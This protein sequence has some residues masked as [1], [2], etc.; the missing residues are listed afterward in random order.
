MTREMAMLR[1]ILNAEHIEWHDASEESE[2]C[3]IC[4]THFEH[5]GYKWSVIHG[6]GTYGGF[7]S[8]DKDKGLLEVMSDAINGGEPIGWLTAEEVMQYVKGDK[9]GEGDFFIVVNGNCPNCGK[10]LNGNRI[11]LCEECGKQERKSNE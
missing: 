1:E 11:F 4:R 2:M 5:R 9:Y 3:P 10:P 8:I 6:Y 7:S